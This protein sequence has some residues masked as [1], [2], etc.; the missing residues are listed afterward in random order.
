[1]RVEETDR[2]AVR[3]GQPASIGTQSATAVTCS[4][5]SVAFAGAARQFA[6]RRILIRRWSVLPAG[7]SSGLDSCRASLDAGFSPGFAVAPVPS[8]VFRSFFFP[9]PGFS[10]RLPELL[11]ARPAARQWVS[12]RPFRRR[13]FGM[14]CRSRRPPG[15]HHPNSARRWPKR[16][17]AGQFVDP[18]QAGRRA[19]LAR[20]V[21][22]F[23]RQRPIACRLVAAANRSTTLESVAFSCSARFQK[24]IV[25]SAAAET[26]VNLAPN[27]APA[28]P[29]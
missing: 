16:R 21:R 25:P 14:I 6:I 15:T 17:R 4:V 18:V 3:H 10:G 28:P 8:A 23:C 5:R 13:S 11:P 1:M 22:S 7:H 24:R 12:A 27:R 20:S 9:S 26:M 2:V 19:S 29:P